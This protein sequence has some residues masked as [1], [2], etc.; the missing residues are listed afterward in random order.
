[1]KIDDVR[2]VLVDDEPGAINMLRFYLEKISYIEI[3]ETFTDATLA[4]EWLLNNKVDLLITDIDMPIF[5]GIGLV[6]ALIEPPQIIYCTSH[7]E[8]AADTFETRPI[9]FLLKP[10]AFDRLQQALGWAVEAIK[11]IKVQ[12]GRVLEP[13]IFVKVL[14]AKKYVN[15]RVHEILY[16]M[17]AGNT[18]IIKTLNDELVVRKSLKELRHKLGATDFIMAERAFLVNKHLIKEVHES[19]LFMVG[20]EKEIQ[21]GP[22]YAANLR[23]FVKSKLW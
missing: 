14:K 1:M 17:V 16:I 6:K 19:K 9:D 10:I 18:C 4:L 13:Y 11:G 7:A 21:I 20:L 5:T 8:F 22:D 23:D 2:V 12:E 3:V 15:V